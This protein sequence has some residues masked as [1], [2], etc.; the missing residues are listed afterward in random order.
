[1]SRF[2]EILESIVAGGDP[3]EL[4]PPQSRNEVLMQAVHAKMSADAAKIA[5]HTEDIAEV[6]SQLAAIDTR[7]DT[8]EDSDIPAYGVAYAGTSSP[9]L[10]RTLNA[11]G[12]T[13]VAW[14]GNVPA[15]NNFDALEPWASIV[16]VNLADDGTVNAIYG[17]PTYKADGTNGQV[18]VRIPKFWYKLTPVV[19]LTQPVYQVSI[20]GYKKADYS[21]H[22]AFAGRKLDGGDLDYI[23]VGAY[24]AGDD[25]GKLTSV[26]GVIPKVSATRAQFRTAAQARGTNWAQMD[27]LAACAVQL[28][29][30]VEYANWDG[31][32]A[33]GADLSALPYTAT[34]LATVATTAANDIII[35]TSLAG[36]YDVGMVIGIGTSLGGNQIAVSRAITAKAIYDGTNTK[37]TFDGAPV[38]VAVGNIVY[39]TGQKTG[40][41]DTVQPGKSGREAGATADRSAMVY[42]GIENLWGNVWT[43]IDGLNIADW[44]WAYCNNIDAYADNTIAGNYTPLEGVAPSADGYVKTMR[45]SDWTFRP[46]TV[47]G[48]SSTYIP[49][50]YY[51]SSGARVLA[52]GGSW[53]FGAADGPF[54]FGADYLSGAAPVNYGGRLLYLP[55]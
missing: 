26:A 5:E 45:L 4:Q 20:S 19:P 52:L 43:W 40:R 51:Q 35:A 55:R 36:T 47:G 27:Y 7:V 14:V 54:S 46:L 11:V 38:S 6:T 10:T 9:A 8:L 17:D 53:G 33:I 48:S 44:V 16:R 49:D 3:A 1:M 37:L 25:A 34:H 30:L 39:A 22:P 50:Y 15:A 42:R 13:A 2:E 41:A 21:V 18:M 24:D 32:T 29:Y 28:L 12:L 31:Q 23:F